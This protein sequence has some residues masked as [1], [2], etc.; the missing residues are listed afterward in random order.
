MWRPPC[1]PGML[2]VDANRC[3]VVDTTRTPTLQVE[4]SPW[5]SLPGIVP[6]Y[7]SGD[8]RW[9]PWDLDTAPF[10]SFLASLQP[11]GHRPARPLQ[12]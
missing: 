1:F 10:G 8:T 12:C 2:Y 5:P 3:I 6:A 4:R 11:R 9:S 7:S